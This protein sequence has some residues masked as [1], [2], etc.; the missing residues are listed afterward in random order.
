VALSSI[1]ALAACSS[2]GSGNQASTS[3]VSSSA[4][5]SGS[6]TSESSSNSES[7][8]TSSESSTSSEAAAGASKFSFLG[9]VSNK[10][11]A[12]TMEALSTGQCSDANTAAPLSTDAVDQD[13]QDQKLQLLAG[14][15]ALPSA[16]VAPNSPQLV[17]QL[18]SA[19]A[20]LDVS[21]VLDKS[22]L[23]D[24]V[25]PAAASTIKKLYGQDDLYA[26]P[27]E[28]N[29]EG[30]WYNKKT[31]AD[32]GITV[33]TTWDDLV[34]AMQ[35]LQAAGVQ[36]IT[37]DGKDGW[38]VTR[39]VG[40]YIFRLLGADAM[41]AV[42][43]G[44]AKLTD[45][46][47]VKAADAVSELGKKGYFGK[48]VASND[49]NGSVNDFLTGKAAMIYMGSWVL[50]NFN[51]P[52]QNK[53]GVDNI[54]F[55]KFPSV[56]DGKG[57]IN[58]IPSNVGQPIV[59]NQ[60]QNGPAMDAWISCIAKNYGDTVFEKSGVVS[61]FA[62]HQPHTVPPLTKVV[63]DEISSASSSVL[64]FEALFSAK[65]TTVSQS[66]GG[67][68]ATGSLSGADFMSKVQAAIG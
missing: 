66:N 19:N 53:I 14:Q 32:N 26:L 27:N 37:A 29:I 28:F 4:G 65:A 38:P 7:A 55:M 18:I 21:K 33:P 9:L 34:A 30:I 41:S 56:T 25:L 3:D 15:G 48:N 2:S 12:M 68:L 31:F 43:N 20:L 42:A 52:A 36:P 62:L 63:Q 6:G 54:G 46:D 16:M 49:Y 51:D 10:T 57:D 8:E 11:P 24:E 1:L 35:K 44:Q 23:T 67:L 13:T 59:L 61:G 39:W 58:D 50:S 47:Y 22:G 60:Q 40:D 64:W 5:E 45:P 17:Q